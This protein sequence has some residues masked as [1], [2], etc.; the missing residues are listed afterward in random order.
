[1]RARAGELEAKAKKQQALADINATNASHD[2]FEE[3]VWNE[4][5][6]MYSKESGCKLCHNVRVEEVAGLDLAGEEEYTHI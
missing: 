2:G 6:K 1:M 3:K 4:K 5:R